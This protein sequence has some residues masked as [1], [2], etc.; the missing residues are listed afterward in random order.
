MPHIVGICETWLDTSRNPAFQGYHPF[1]RRDRNCRGG[2]IAFLIRKY[3]QFYTFQ[4]RAF[5]QGKLEHLFIYIAFQ[6]KWYPILIVYNPCQNVT[7]NEFTHYI[8]KMP[9]HS[10]IMGDFNSKHSY[11]QTNISSTQMNFSSHSLFST[12]SYYR[13]TPS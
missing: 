3:L 12:Q 2:K 1:I 5:P 13:N 10:M 6:D 9:N 7:M 11:W 4:I 8:D